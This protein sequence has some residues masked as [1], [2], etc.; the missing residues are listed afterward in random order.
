MRHNFKRH[1][2]VG[3]K[4]DLEALKGILRGIDPESGSQAAPVALPPPQLQDE[5]R[6]DNDDA[7]DSQD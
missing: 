4:S 7:D 1:R 2:G 3:N 5:K 6:E